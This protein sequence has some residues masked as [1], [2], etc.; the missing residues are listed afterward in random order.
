MK[1]SSN[2]KNWFFYGQRKIPF[3]KR[4]FVVRSF[5]SILWSRYQLAGPFYPPLLHTHSHT[6]THTRTHIQTQT[7]THTHSHTHTNTHIQ[8]HTHS[9]T[10]THIHTHT[11][12]HTHTHIQT[13]THT[14]TYTN[15]H[16][17]TLSQ[18]LL[19]FHSL[20]GWA[21]DRADHSY[22]LEPKNWRRKVRRNV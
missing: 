7:H 17:H 20:L 22:K 5:F 19:E 11:N 8:T 21:L 15:T 13:H 16:T 9:H 14:N 1:L 12:I 10:N 4:C 3:E 18:I 2:I 6:N